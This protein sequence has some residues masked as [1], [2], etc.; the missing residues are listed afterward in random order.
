MKKTWISFFFLLLNLSLQAQELQ[1]RLFEAGFENVQVREEKDTLKIF[2]EHREFRS[3]YHSMTYADL[4]LSETVE[5][6]LLWIPIHHNQPIGRYS[7]EE[8]K[9]S[10]LTAAD[11]A[12]FRRANELSAYRFH[13]RIHPDFAARFGYY[14]DP[15]QI[16]FNMIV[17][18]RIYLAP[19]LSL[20][21]G[22]SVPIQNNLDAQ[23]MNPRLAPT[24]LHWFSQPA[25]SHFLAVS[26]GSFFYDRYG[27]DLQYRY[28]PLDSRW[29]FGLE[30][31][32]TG[33]YWMNA[34]SFYSE[35][36]SAFHAI[37]DA[38]VRLPFENLSLKLSA[39]QFLFEDKGARVDL[40]RQYG[41]AEI[42]LHA[43][44]TDEG[45]SGGFQFAFSFWPGTIL[46]TKKLEL[47][48]TEEFRWEYSYN[49]EDPVA[50]SYRLGIPRLDDLLR[51]YN[52]EF[53]QSLD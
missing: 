21:T 12:F 23:D 10:E 48:T 8:Y 33:F 16:K 43:A 26:L 32:L 49:N 45:V 46:R 35:E 4:L 15:F 2:F 30:T 53:V 14:S 39:G 42:G 5:K 36:L 28:A 3:P 44:V 51:R 38:E 29:S 22:V 31:G 17:D 27:L 52:E 11:K 25:N 13:F 1:K 18:T 40:I 34:G 6:E 24:M 50:R 47:R 41:G 9:F 19:G 7:A 20:Q 37:A